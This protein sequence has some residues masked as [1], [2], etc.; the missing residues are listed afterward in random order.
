MI[1]ES[2][3]STRYKQGV[4]QW[5]AGGITRPLQEYIDQLEDKNIKILIPG[6]GHGHEL[7]YLLDQGFTNVYVI[8]IAQEPLDYIKERVPNL[9]KERILHGDFFDINDSFDLILEQTFFC[10]LVPE[11]REQYVI[12]VNSLLGEHGKLVGVLFDFPMD[13]S[14]LPPFGGGKEEYASLFSKYMHVKVLQRCYNSIKPREN[15]ELFINI[16][17]KK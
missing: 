3:W 14:G 11:L 17:K 4:T 1:N 10:A 9:V 7:A 5:D 8:D 2:F 15:R 13:A 6:V 16:E 12:K